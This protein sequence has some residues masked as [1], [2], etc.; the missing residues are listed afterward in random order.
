MPHLVKMD[1]KYAKDGM[2]LIG[3]EVQGSEIPAIEDAVKEHKLKFPVTKGISGPNLSNGIPHM[4]VFDAK[5]KMLAHGHPNS[6]EIE[7][8]IKT[9]MK[10]AT[11]VEEK[12]GS[13]SVF[14]NKPKDLVAE[15]EW[16]N[17]EGKKIK[18]TLISVDGTKGQFR[19]PNGRSFDYDITSLSKEDQ[20]M[21][22]EKSEKKDEE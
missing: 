11:P 18:A 7:K 4:A 1:K 2:V 17:A 9:A 20:E 6:P 15:R 13:G 16:T 19:F 3:A 8:A 5:G 12:S 14:D 21:I 10:G 22:A